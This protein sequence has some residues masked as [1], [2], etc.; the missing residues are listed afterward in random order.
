VDIKNVNVSELI[1]VVEHPLMMLV[2][3]ATVYSWLRS[4]RLESVRLGTRWYSTNEKIEEFIKTCSTPKARYVI[5]RA[6]EFKAAEDRLAARRRV[7]K[8]GA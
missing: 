8:A 6:K 4:G 5:N 7:G 3:R 1:Q 2:S